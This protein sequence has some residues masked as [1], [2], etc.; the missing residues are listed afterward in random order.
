[1]KTRLTHH[2]REKERTRTLGAVLAG[3]LL[4]GTGAACSSDETT[5]DP[6]NESSSEPRAPA[7]TGV[8]PAGEPSSGEGDLPQGSEQVELDPAEFMTEIDNPYWPMAPGNRWVYREIDTDGTVQKVVVTVT[9]KTKMIAN[10][11]EARVVHD[12]VS[13]QGELV[14]VTDDWYAQDAAGNV[15][16]LG[17]ETAEYENGKPVSTSGSF[18]AGVD[19]AQA[20]IAMPANPQDGMAYRQEYYKGEAEDRAEVLS[21]DEKAEVPFGYYKATLMTK[22]LVPTEPKVSEHKFYAEGVG[23]VLTLDIAGGTGREELLSFRQG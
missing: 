14:E 6:G 1:M 7:S 21:L 17:E 12:V 3:A 4:V 20:G 19:G 5:S 9:D 22:D 10:G 15:W 16:Y 8:E 2:S 23:P 11:I 18:E 13:S